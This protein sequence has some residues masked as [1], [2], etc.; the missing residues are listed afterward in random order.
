MR[1]IAN[2]RH[3]ASALSAQ[4]PCSEPLLAAWWAISLDAR[5]VDVTLAQA[6]AS[7]PVA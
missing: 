6:L 5:P 4:A 7:L 2:P 1:I 3:L